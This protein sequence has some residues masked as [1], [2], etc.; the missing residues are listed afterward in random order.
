MVILIQNVSIICF[1]KDRNPSTSWQ[2]WCGSTCRLSFV[3]SSNERGRAD[4]LLP[5][6]RKCFLLQSPHTSWHS[7]TETLRACVSF[8]I[9]MATS[10]HYLHN[11]GLYEDR[12]RC[13]HR[14]MC[15]AGEW[16][17]LWAQWGGVSGHHWCLRET[18]WLS[19]TNAERKWA[20]I[21]V[22]LHCMYS[23]TFLLDW[24]DRN[25]SAVTRVFKPML[26]WILSFLHINH[27]TI[28]FDKKDNLTYGA[29]NWVKT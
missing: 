6:V 17:D 2:R 27:Y 22:V 7:V 28:G 23:K 10:D 26:L 13:L 24:L 3:L 29:E 4:C 12:F 25:I 18:T 20:N 1:N 8:G 19:Q 16:R 21:T 9:L 11:V 5:S 14:K 15:C